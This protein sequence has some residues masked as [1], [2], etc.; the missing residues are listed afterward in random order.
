MTPPLDRDRSRRLARLLAMG[1]MGL[2]IVAM[3]APQLPLRPW[4]GDRRG[5]SGALLLARALGARDLALGLGA[6]LAL[7]HDGAVRGWVEAGGMADAGDAVVTVVAFR[8]LPARG[9]WAVLGAATS[10]A[11]AARLAAPGVDLPDPIPDRPFP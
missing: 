9:R 8:S 10:G 5:D 4:V 2:G 11:V 3:A 6:L 1:R 7:R